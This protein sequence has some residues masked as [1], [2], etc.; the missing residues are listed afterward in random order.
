LGYQNN[1]TDKLALS[2]GLRYQSMG[3]FSA[4]SHTSAVTALKFGEESYITVIS[5]LR[6]HYI[7]APLKLNYLLNSKNSIGIAY[8]VAYLLDVESKVE[9]YLTSKDRHEDLRVS[10]SMGY[11]TGFS[12]TDGQIAFCYRRQIYKRLLLNCE[13]F[14]GMKDIKKNLVYHSAIFERSRGLK[15]TLTYNLIKK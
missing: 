4:T 8:T 13:L 5:P 6:A 1:F 15:L 14:Y 2:L 12:S 3:N 7:A 9:T 10:K 11:K